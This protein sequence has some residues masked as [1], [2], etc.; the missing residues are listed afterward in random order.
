MVDEVRGDRHVPDIRKNLRP[1][2]LRA[3]R[4]GCVLGWGLRIAGV[5]VSAFCNQ[6]NATSSEEEPCL[7]GLLSLGCVLVGV[8]MEA[9]GM[10]ISVVVVL[11]TRAL[12]MR[13]SECLP[14]PS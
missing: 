6:A 2:D 12:V 3:R 5:T 10:A 13:T 4:L 14:A 8:A 9:P 1:P 7:H 11:G